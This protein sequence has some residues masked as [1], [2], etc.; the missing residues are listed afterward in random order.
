MFQTPKGTRDIFPE[1]ME[2]LNFIIGEFIK[3]FEKYGFKPLDT[4]AF[5]SFE[6]LSA[7]GAGQSLKD[8]IY[9]FK[10][11]SGR[12]LGLRFDLTVPLSRFISNNPNLPKPFKRYQI[13]KVWRY[14]NPQ[15]LR[16]REFN[17]A[18]IDIVG[19]KSMLADTECLAV[20]AECLQAIG[21]K[22]FYIR[23]NNRKLLENILEKFNV[24]KNKMLD[25]FRAIDKIDKIGLENVKKELKKLNVDISFF[26]MLKI[27]DNY[28]FLEEIKNKFGNLE[29]LTELKEILDLSKTLGC[30]KYLKI[31]LSLA[32][33]LEY[34]TGPV[35]EVMIKD[36]QVSC[37]GGGR[38]DNL[39]KTLGGPDLPAVGI[40]FGL[41]RI[42]NVFSKKL[43][44]NRI[45]VASASDSVRNISLKI[46]KELRDSGKI[47]DIDNMDRKLSKQIEYADSMKYSY[48]IIVGEEELKRNSVKIKDMKTGKERI[49]EIKNLKSEL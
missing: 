6:L 1:E 26:S 34:Y 32:R 49:V 47:C 21:I 11:K 46:A 35:F 2:K 23:I 22:N 40:S 37:G 43:E 29:G 42:V 36:V 28:R 39:I 10:D 30:D 44:K 27:E 24:P 12:E 9:Y 48:V 4:P 31:D 19:S 17:Q 14:D 8:E 13:G 18:D 41:D 38:Y 25:V 7:K 20:A 3:V 16:F 5:E 33:G 15:A 45:F